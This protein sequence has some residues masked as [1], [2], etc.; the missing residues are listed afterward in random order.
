MTDLLT[1]KSSA[2]GTTTRRPLQTAAIMAGFAAAA[3][4]LALC[5]AAAVV[6]WFLADAGSHGS[7]T[8]AL[9][10]GADG[11]LLG[12]GSRTV[13][14][15]T[16][17]GI[18]PLTLTAGLVLIG[19]RCGRQA[20]SRSTSDVDDRTL[21]TAIGL[22]TLGY[23]VSLVLVAVLNTHDDADPS[24]SRALLGGVLVS[25]LGL[26]T[27]LAHGTGRLV[28]WWERVPLFARTVAQ[29]AA[30]AAL[31]M[32]AA[33]ALLAAAAFVFSFNDASMLMSSLRLGIGDA[34]MVTV[35]TAFVAPNAALFGAAW[36]IGPGFSVGTDTVVSPGEVTL[37][38]LPNFPLLAALPADGQVAGYLAAAM[39]VP[40]LVAAVAAGWAQRRY[41]VTAWDSAALRGFAVGC[42]AALLLTLAMLLAGGPMGTGRMVDIGPPVAEV[43]VVSVGG[44]SLGGLVGGLLVT[45]WQRSQD[46]RRDD[47]GIR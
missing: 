26:G 42:G 31:A 41:A 37:G 14:D 3:I 19:F 23:L 8:D 11:W 5:M 16:P 46:R 44:M 35:L 36:L 18:L 2:E 43:L 47:S 34:L 17:L 39:A 7:T 28:A 6:G 10:I 21:G 13:L 4:G 12:H 1:R 32:G 22:A 24:L 33:G 30:L 38:P 29:G 9:R 40:V 27:G 25:A 45:A 20:T 15:G